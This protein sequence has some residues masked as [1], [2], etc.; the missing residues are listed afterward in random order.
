MD[1]TNMASAV[2]EGRGPWYFLVLELIVL[3][4]AGRMRL[5]FSN[6]SDTIKPF[7]VSFLQ[8]I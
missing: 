3:K 1:L 5:T 6:Q 4:A 7:H 8:C 2:W